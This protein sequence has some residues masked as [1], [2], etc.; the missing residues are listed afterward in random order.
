MNPQVVYTSSAAEMFC[1]DSGSY[2]PVQSDDPDPTDQCLF[3][4]PFSVWTALWHLVIYRYW[5][6]HSAL[7]VDS[8]LGGV[9]NWHVRTRLHVWTYVNLNLCILWWQWHDLQDLQGL[10]ERNS[11]MEN[12]LIGLRSR[13][14]QVRFDW[15]MSNGSLDDIHN[16]CATLHSGD[17]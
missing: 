14:H 2:F 9:T 1:T 15:I 4:Q 6:K 13:K 17:F 16:R 11:L 3:F 10:L 8:L 12:W 5:D 7:R